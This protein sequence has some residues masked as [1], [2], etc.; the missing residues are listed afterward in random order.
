MKILITQTMKTQIYKSG[1]LLAFAVFLSSSTLSSQEVSKAFHQEYTAGSGTTLDISNKYGDVVVETTDQNQIIIDVK[2]TVEYPNKERAEKLLSYINVEFSEVGDVVKARTIIDDK[3]NF[4]GWGGGS[5][6][7]SIDYKVIMPARI[8]FTL[9]N[10]YGDSELDEIRG[11]V[12]L[13]IKYGDLVAENLARG[14]EKPYNTL[15]VAYGKASIESAG[16][17]DATVRYSGS[18]AIGKAQAMLIDSKYS[19]IQIEDISSVVGDTKYDNI[20]IEKINNLV[21]NAGYADI[22]VG[23]L[24]KKLK[25][26][27]GYGSLTVDNVPAGFEI[28]ESD[29]RYI[30]IKLG[31]D[32]DASYELDAKLSY[33]DLK[34]DEE[35]FRH[36]RRIV[37]N[38][39]SETTGIV[40]KESSPSSK[41]R[42]TASYGSIRLY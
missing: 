20:D 16:W 15:S 21:L 39:S 26:E 42:V 10:R 24:T 12:K 18:F 1:L 38:N 4:S 27:G 28:L 36:Q 23:E 41:V 9:S 34:F 32:S 35:N 8:N 6:S 13:D 37:Q 3:F 30:G 5:K 31:I 29:S 17:L 14:N 7:F 33:G 25:F 22:N 19:K 2:V 40:G 11:L